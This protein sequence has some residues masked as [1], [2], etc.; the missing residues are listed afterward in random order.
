MQ[1]LVILT[2]VLFFFYSCKNKEKEEEIVDIQEK[3]E[4]PNSSLQIPVLSPETS[5]AIA[6]WQRFQEFEDDLKRINQ[7]GIRR[8]I[9]ETERMA[10]AADSL[11]I[12][13]PQTLKSNAISSRMRVV[14]ARTKL[15]NEALHQKGSDSLRVRNNLIETNLAY[16]NLLNQINEKFEKQRI[17]SLAKTDKNI[18]INKKQQR[19]DSI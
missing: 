13:I 8:Y 11:L 16:T 3:V 1:K 7:S 14:N 2:V 6:S 17:D 12:S 5:N 18:D 4:V 19:N 10:A 15:L 9:R